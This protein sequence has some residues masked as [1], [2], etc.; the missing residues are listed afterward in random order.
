MPYSTASPTTDPSSP[1]SG[2]DSPA[3][4]QAQTLEQEVLALSPLPPSRPLT[5]VV[6]RNSPPSDNDTH[7]APEDDNDDMPPGKG[8][9]HS[10]PGVHTTR[11]TVPPFHRAPEDDLVDAK[12][13]RFTINYAGEPTI[14]ATMGRG[15]PHYAL[16]IMAS[17]VEG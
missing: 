5:P 14:E 9:F 12:Y 1:T 10:Q 4:P 17:P 7:P 16:P 8:W 3:P 2:Q 6:Q 11:L 15:K 13:L